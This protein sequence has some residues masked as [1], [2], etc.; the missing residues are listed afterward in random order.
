MANLPIFKTDDRISM[1]QQ[2][3][4]ARTLNP[5]LSNPLNSVKVLKDVA[6]TTGVNVI[7]HLLDSQQQGWF[8]VDKQGAGDVYR[9]QPFN[10]K[11]LTLTSTANMTVSIGV[12]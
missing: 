11:T 3:S 4:W 9:S 12:Y 10:N 2:N 5:F 1:M 7:N 8:L 6:L